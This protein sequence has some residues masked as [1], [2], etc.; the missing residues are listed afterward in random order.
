MSSG[1]VK[2]GFVP[3][4]WNIGGD[5]PGVRVK[6]LLIILLPWLVVVVMVQGGR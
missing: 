1:I 5:F 4:L 3:H 6:P 2:S